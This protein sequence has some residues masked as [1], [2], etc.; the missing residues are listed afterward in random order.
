MG[1]RSTITRCWALLL[2]GVGSTA[3]AADLTGRIEL[4]ASCDPGV[5][6]AVVRLEPAEGTAPAPA[7]PDAAQAGVKLVVNQKLLQF[8]PRVLGGTV[9]QRLTFTNADSEQHNVHLQGPGINFSRTIGPGEV[10]E[11]TPT[12]PGLIRVFCD[13]HSHMR[14]FV[15]VA[16]SPYVAVCDR[17]GKFRFR[18]VPEGAYTLH[19][20]HELGD[21]LVQSVTVAA[22]AHDLGTLT[23]KGPEATTSGAVAGRVEPWSE[24][25]DRISVAL[26]GALDIVNRKG[27]GAAAR[28]VG[29]VDDAYL[30]VFEGSDMETAVRTA[31]GYDRAI[32]IETRF[33]TLRREARQ[34]AEGKLG[35]TA[36]GNSVRGLLVELS[37]AA[38]DLNAKGIT[39]RTRVLAGSTATAPASE[40]AADTQAAQL[41]A[42]QSAFARVVAQADAGQAREAAADLVT[43]YFEEFE[44]LERTLNVRNP[45]SVQPLEAR[46]AAIR[47]QIEA[48]ARAQTLQTSLDGLHGEIQTALARGD[49]SNASAFGLG[50]AASLWIAL[51]EGV[52][53]IL[54]LTMLTTLVVKAGRPRGALAALWWGVGLAVLASGATAYAL[55]RLVASSRGRTGEILEGLVMLAAAGVLFYVSYW[56]ISQSESKRWMGFLKRQAEQGASGRGFFTLGLTA[57]LAVFREGAETTLMYQALL[58]NQSPQGVAGIVAGVGLGVVLL[59]ILA[60]VLRVTSLKLPMRAFFQ[61]TGC[62]L[63][64]MAVIFAGN[65]VLELQVA[66]VL[67]STPLAAL[68]RG[69]PWLGL[70]P[71]IQGVAVQGL[72]LLGAVLAFVVIRQAREPGQAVTAA[73]P[74]VVQ[75]SAPS[76]AADAADAAAASAPAPAE[77]LVAGLRS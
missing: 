8:R 51:R 34:A 35:A 69:I 45:A 55:N 11:F 43:A 44:P 2:L 19:V 53:V 16:G 70:H 21:P 49:G 46:F 9:G 33:R 15:V 5:S 28:A 23:V 62:L 18:N 71:S 63:F 42:L 3:P 27:D 13:I 77:P 24:V 67:R 52:E 68:G 76:P 66:G 26:A 39:D 37:Q 4:P 22:G 31:L 58:A 12:G 40:P 10:V 60:V 1:V 56:L 74:R 57:F 14:A 73:G 54:L 17:T 32:G 38:G 6:P 59:A 20:W 25:I 36:L 30:A 48:G 64:A 47:G 61:V 29:K 72:L 50:F 7:A 75:A 41:A 65:A